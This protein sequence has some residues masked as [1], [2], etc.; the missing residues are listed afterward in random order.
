LLV[1]LQ[2]SKFCVYAARVLRPVELRGSLRTHQQNK[3]CIGELKLKVK[4]REFELEDKTNTFDLPTSNFTQSRG[5]DCFSKL[6]IARVRA[7]R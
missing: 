2:V 7:P 3:F 5:K 4:V 6:E 1:L